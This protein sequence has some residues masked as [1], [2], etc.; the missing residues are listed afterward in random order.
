MWPALTW[1]VGLPRCVIASA[2][3]GNRPRWTRSSPGGRTWLNRLRW[4]V[5]DAWTVARRDLIHWVRQP[6]GFVVN[7]LFP[8]M[9]VLMFGYL[10]GGAISVP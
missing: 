8:V 9:M 7:L 10:F 4:A 6:F 2:W 3:R 1:C 5:A